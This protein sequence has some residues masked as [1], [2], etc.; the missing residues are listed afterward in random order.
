MSS[1]T[2]SGYGGKGAPPEKPKAEGGY[3]QRYREP[4]RENKNTA[5][6][7]T[8]IFTFIGLTADLKGHIYDVGTGSQAN[9]FT[10]TT[11][12]LASYAGRKCS[13]PQDIQIAIEY[14]KDISIPIPITRRDIDEEVANIHLGKDIDAY[15]KL[16]Q[17]YRQNK[18]KIYS[19]TLGQCMEATDNR[20]EGEETYEDTDGD[21]EVIRLLLLINSISYSYE[22]KSYPVLATHMALRKFYLSYKSSSSS[23]DEYNEK[24]ERRYL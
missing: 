15:V 9:Q 24:P 5:A 20:F 4:R 6:I 19:V 18:A 22:S 1:K 17:Q 21:S 13:D 11:K 10:T 23:S 8:E 3:R 2:D 12:A 7:S 14:Q 16:S